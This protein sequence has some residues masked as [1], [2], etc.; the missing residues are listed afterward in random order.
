MDREA[1]QEYIL[2]AC[3]DEDGG[4]RDKPHKYDIIRSCFPSLECT[5]RY[6]YLSHWHV[7]S[8]YQPSLTLNR[9]SDYYHTCY[10][11]S[12]LSIAQHYTSVDFDAVER[13]REHGLDATRGGL[14]SLM[15][16]D[17]DEYIVVGNV[18]NLVVSSL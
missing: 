13:V 17:S 8:P 12:G 15:W 3:Q 16:R 4:L 2:V 6:Y 1:L 18:E 10:C 5:K 11:L 9:G 7:L 14:S